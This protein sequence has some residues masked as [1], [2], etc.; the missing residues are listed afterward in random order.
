MQIKFKEV[1]NRFLERLEVDSAATYRKK[2]YVF[3]DYLIEKYDA[4]NINFVSILKDLSI[5]DVMDSVG[6]YVKV[7]DKGIM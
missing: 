3:Y 6:Y 4:T 1:V 2:I 5:D 7:F